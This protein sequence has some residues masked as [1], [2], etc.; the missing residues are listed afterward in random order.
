M[1]L[2]QQVTLLAL[3]LHWTEEQILAL[4]PERR[5]GYLEELE[6]LYSSNK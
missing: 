6:Q 3:K 4:T 5:S 2:R 1:G